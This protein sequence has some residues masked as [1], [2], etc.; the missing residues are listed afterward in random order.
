MNGFGWAVFVSFASLSYCLGDGVGERM[1]TVSVKEAIVSKAKVRK[2]GFEWLAEPPRPKFRDG[3]STLSRPGLLSG[4][5]RSKRQ[6]G[7]VGVFLVPQWEVVELALDRQGLDFHFHEFDAAKVRAGEAALFQKGDRRYGIVVTSAGD[8]VHFELFFPPVG[9]GIEASGEPTEVVSLQSGS[10][11]CWV[12]ELDR[13]RLRVA[14]VGGA[15][16]GLGE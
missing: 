5:S 8:T 16:D 12:E 7:L 6:M 1:H 9:K 4:L 3:T 13:E 10:V 11:L 2:A 15:I 14:L